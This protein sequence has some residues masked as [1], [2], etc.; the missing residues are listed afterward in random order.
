MLWWITETRVQHCSSSVLASLSNCTSSSHNTV[1][2]KRAGKTLFRRLRVCARVWV[3]KRYSS[4][5]DWMEE[6]A[7]IS[8]LSALASRPDTLPPCG[9]PVSWQRSWI[10]YP[11]VCLS[12]PS[13]GHRG[14]C[15]LVI[16]SLQVKM[17]CGGA[18]ALA[19]SPCPALDRRRSTLSLPMA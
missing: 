4:K 18:A 19:L 6:A 17:T 7:A 11:S 14:S 12:V 1:R 8:Y 10:M 5:A 2:D 3:R 15:Q 16:G 13:T 9:F